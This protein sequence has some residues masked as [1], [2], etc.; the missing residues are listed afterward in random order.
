MITLRAA[1]PG[2]VSG[3]VHAVQF[4]VYTKREGRGRWTAADGTNYYEVFN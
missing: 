4:R 1:V 2:G 3:D